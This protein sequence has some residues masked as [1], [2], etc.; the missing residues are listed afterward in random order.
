LK[1]IWQP[2]GLNLATV[3]SSGGYFVQDIIQDQLSVINLN[4]MYF[5]EKNDEVSDCDSSSSAGAV[6]LKWLEGVLQKYQKKSGNHQVYM[7]SHVPPIDDDGSK[8]YKSSCYKQYM[9]L[10]GE[11]GSV[12]SGHFTGH[13]NSEYKI[14]VSRHVE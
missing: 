4:S 2:L 10:L 3:F 14:S 6:Q 11:Y 5:Y 7:M 9:N 1:T 8:L 12:I 13:T